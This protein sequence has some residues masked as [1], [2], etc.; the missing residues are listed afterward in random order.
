MD[1]GKNNSS[2]VAH[3]KSMQSSLLPTSNMH[4]E[5][6]SNPNK[7]GESVADVHKPLPAVNQKHIIRGFSYLP[8][9]L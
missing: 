2:C 9:H 3:L 1:T 5:K 8:F 4:P 7:T 6:E